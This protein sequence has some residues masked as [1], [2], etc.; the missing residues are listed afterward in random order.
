M[1]LFLVKYLKN[2][3]TS[4]EY[5]DFRL[6]WSENQF[7]Y[8]KGFFGNNTIGNKLRATL[9]WLII[10]KTKTTDFKGTLQNSVYTTSI[11]SSGLYE[12]IG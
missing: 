1:L 12:N 2:F 8:A 6:W 10:I 7:C 4:M 9:L 3:T 5:I 11:V